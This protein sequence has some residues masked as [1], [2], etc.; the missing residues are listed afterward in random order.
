[1][2]G[3]ARRHEEDRTGWNVPA[4][5]VP[6]PGRD[7]SLTEKRETNDNAPHTGRPRRAANRG[8]HRPDARQAPRDDRAPPRTR[9]GAQARMARQRTRPTLRRTLA[10]AHRER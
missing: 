7:P 2:A 9:R 10:T 3:R 8:R 5:T 1:R 6:G 4:V